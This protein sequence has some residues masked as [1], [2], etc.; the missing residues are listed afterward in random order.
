MTELALELECLGHSVTVLTTTPHYNLDESALAR[1]PMERR[2]GGLL[3]YSECGGIPVWHVKIPVKG[4]RVW[5]RALDYVRF[6]L[7][8]L[9]ASVLTLGAQ[10]IVI[11]TSPPLTIGI[12]SWLLGARWEAPSVYKVA[13]IYPDLAIRQGVV[14]NPALIKLMR[15]LEQVVY[16]RNTMMVPIAEQFKRLL[17]ERGVPSSKLWVIP[18][19]VDTELYRPMSRANPFAEEHELLDDFVILYGGNIG[20]VQDWDAVLFAAETVSDL[21]IQFVIVGDGSRREWLTGE[22]KKR[23]L[24]NVRLFGYQPKELMSQINASC[25]IAMIPMTRIGTMG[26]FPSKIY[27]IMACAKPVIASA[28]EDSE[29]AWIVKQS[30][31][32]VVVPCE[33]P[34]AFADAV[35]AVFRERESLPAKG[36]RGRRFVEQDYSK[37]AI[38]QK[39]DGLIR[40]LTRQ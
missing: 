37:R 31:C 30:G 39:Y 5:A 36:E 23:G 38:A 27:T 14:R 8:S 7:V 12:M 9:L 3:Y 28:S 2:W 20:L 19:F 15:W 24:A 16:A 40:Q 6:H 29:M 25:D 10:D 35:L 11:A 13:E 17:C 33:D 4:Q 18:D 21:P 26:G 22:V 34:Q 32:G 1:Q